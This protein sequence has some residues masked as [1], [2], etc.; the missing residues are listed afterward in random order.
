MF[1]IG[2][3]FC[4]FTI[5]AIRIRLDA[6]GQE[7]QTVPLAE[8]RVGIGSVIQGERVAPTNVVIYLLTSQGQVSRLVSSKV[9]L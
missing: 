6:S 7:I 3:S 4:L 8:G 9:G 5:L 1:A 2:K